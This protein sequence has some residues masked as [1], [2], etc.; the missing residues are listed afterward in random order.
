MIPLPSKKTWG[1]FVWSTD[2]EACHSRYTIEKNNVRNNIKINKNSKN[3]PNNVR[4]IGKTEKNINSEIKKIVY[5][6]IVKESDLATFV[7]VSR[8]FCLAPKTKWMIGL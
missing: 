2:L 7:E 6:Y 1:F 3:A 8:K 5:I 4:K